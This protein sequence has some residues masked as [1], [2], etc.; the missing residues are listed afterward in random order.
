MKKTITLLL[1]V[2]FVQLNAQNTYVPDD[3]FE[4]ALIDLGYD[5]GPL[6]DY[7]PTA[8]INTVTTLEIASKNIQDLTGIEAFTSLEYLGCAFNQI[9]TLDLSS[10]LALLTLY[11]PNNQLSVIDVSQNVNL[12]TLVCWGNY[13][14]HTLDVS[15]NVNLEVLSCG[16]TALNSLNVSTN[17]LLTSLKCEA[18]GLTNMDITNNTLLTEVQLQNN[19]LTGLDISQNTALQSLHIASNGL[20]S[21]DTST[22][23]NLQSVVA[24]NNDVASLDLSSNTNLTFV[25]VRNNPSLHI[26]NVKNGNN[27]N[28]SNF[29]ADNNPNL[30]CILVDDAAYSTANWTYIDAQ[31]S[32]NDVQ[33]PVPGLTYVPDD[34]FEQKLIDLGYDSGTLDDFVTTANIDTVTTLDVSNLN[35][36]DLTGIED[37]IALQT[38]NCSSNQISSLDLSQNVAL[39]NLNCSS[40]SLSYLNVKN[41]N[42]SNIPTANF[43][44]TNNPNLTCILVDDA[45]Y[46]TTNWTNIDAQ[47]VFN[48][49]SCEPLTYVP[50]DNFEQALIDL[51][52][53][54]A[55]DD[56]VITSH[57]NAITSLTV[58]NKN[59]GSLTGIEDFIS[60]ETLSCTQ[61]NISNIDISANTALTTLNVSNNNL[62][63][64]IL[65][66]NVNLTTLY[67]LGNNLTSLD[68]SNN[69]LLTSLNCGYNNNLHTL[70]LSSNTALTSLVCPSIGLSGIDVS[71]NVLLTNLEVQNNQLTSLDISQN[72]N[73]QNLRIDNNQISHL[74]LEN[75]TNLET[76]NI[77]FNLFTALNVNLNTNLTFVNASNNDLRVLYV[78]NGNNTNFTDFYA[79]N[80]P[81]LTCILVDDPLYSTTNWTNIDSQTSFN[82]VSCGF[83]FVP[84][85]NFEQALID[86]TYDDV[87]DDYVPTTNIDTVTTLDVSDSSIS[88]L[89]GLE[90]FT[91][92]TELSCGLNNLSS[93][94]ISANTALTILYCESSNLSSL[95]VS[96]NTALVELDCSENNLSS[97]DTTTNTALTDL[98]C[99][100]NNISNL[101]ISTNT[102]LINLHCGY[103]NLN[104]LNVTSNT[105]LEQL[106]CQNTT[107]SS[108]NVSANTALTR[109]VCTNNNLT[110]LDVS[111]NTALIN[112]NCQNNNLSSLNV[113]NGNNTNIIGFNATNNPNLTC[114]IV[115]NATYSTANW[116]AID[117]TSAFVNSQAECDALGIEDTNLEE[118]INIYPNPVKNNF[119]ITNNG[120]F[121]INKITIHNLLGKIVY[122]ANAIKNNIDISNLKEGIYLVK[123]NS[124][125]ISV[126]KKIIVSK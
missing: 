116:T 15:Q 95:D 124:N 94:D 45:V 110:N 81:N 54:D 66:Q 67:C 59:I 30:T 39:T 121:V 101:D 75:K 35:I 16:F 41:G 7:V 122:Q 27:I 65:T 69:T 43:N 98:N 84:D 102:A 89:T 22:N 8:N 44:A 117:A 26:L 38:L 62:T 51:G 33:C 19:G 114:I 21:L 53:D 125:T 72:S 61:N 74:N 106:F 2:L 108:L 111:F 58:N 28:F 76:L 92:L 120:N 9:T 42:N 1:L 32:F 70:D 93:L 5:S 11:A 17:T 13:S 123:L 63:S 100:S 14:L 46:S 87:L 47:T 115:D 20:T 109:L 99:E 83:T 77:N 107:I 112:F 103:N 79:T 118:A 4:Q 96:A 88:D 48:N 78:K 24:N 18:I 36:T 126:I 10:N 55:L 86:L 3:N 71:N 23:T 113:K 73:L 82:T 12:T 29:Y 52:Y 90:D 119:T 34:N 104:G 25:N 91:A 85:D 37:F 6:D 68:V 64:L 97:L 80:N 40:N 56:Y 60:L 105:A 57:I 49:I 50:D 31:T